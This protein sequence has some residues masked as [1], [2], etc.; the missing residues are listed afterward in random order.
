MHIHILPAIL[1][2]K[3]FISVDSAE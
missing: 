2:W 3:F 1:F